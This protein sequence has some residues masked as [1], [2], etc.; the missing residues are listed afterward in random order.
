[1]LALKLAL[2]P[3]LLAQAL[4]ARRTIPRLPEATGPRE[5]VVGRGAAGPTLLIVGDS[6]AAG[7]GVDTQ[8]EA[9]AG[10]L[11]QALA[12][13]LGRRVRW[14]LCASSGLTSSQ[15]L[16]LLAQARPADVAVV[17]TGVNDVVEQVRPPQALAARERLVAALRERAGVRHVV[18]TP[19]PP[20][21]RF[22]G[23]PQPLRWVAG[24]DAAAHEA[25]LQ[26]WAAGQA[27]VSH[28]P[29]DL[30]LDDATLLARDGFHPGAPLYRLWGDALARHIAEAVWP[31]LASHRLADPSDTPTEDPAW[32]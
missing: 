5:G 17:V 3:L 29:F 22:A 9:L 10:R 16:A 15:A 21:G 2:G 27:Q 4:H 14:Q 30:P 28:L 11:S 12:R 1:M 25:A 20:M 19:V 32:T 6:S 31:R 13:R 7:V 8:D 26:R 23:L 18:L 24:R